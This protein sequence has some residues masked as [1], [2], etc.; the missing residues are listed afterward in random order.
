MTAE[1][2][3]PAKKQAQPDKLYSAYNNIAV[4]SFI[5]TGAPDTLSQLVLGCPD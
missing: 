3:P 2:L 1:H 4:P 5:L